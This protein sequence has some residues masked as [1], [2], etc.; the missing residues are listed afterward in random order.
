MKKILFLAMSFLLICNFTIMASAQEEGVYENAGQLYDAWVS[1]DCVPDYIS[2]VWSTDGGTVNLT[3]GVVKGVAG[4]EGVQEILA[5][6]KNDATVTIEYQTYSR[7]Y[8]YR[9][10]REIEDAYFE[11]GVGLVTAGV[12]ERENKLRFEVHTDFADNADTQAMIQHVAEQYGDAVYF[13]YTDAYIQFVN[14]TQASTPTNPILVMVNPQNQM[15]SFGFAMVLCTVV[16][17]FL[18]FMQIQRRRLLAVTATG[19]TEVVEEY[20][21]SQRELENT[22]RQSEVAPSEA[23]DDCVMQSISRIPDNM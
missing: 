11:A 2:G 8:L 4:E 22:I 21:I 12:M 9:I 16:L 1:Q 7:N 19:G 3:F 18:L 15:M 14:G 13:S 20:P 10:Q 23:L 17:V 6:V 5:L